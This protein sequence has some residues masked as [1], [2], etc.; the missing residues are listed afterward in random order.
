MSEQTTQAIAPIPVLPDEQTPSDR[1]L[2][3]FARNPQ[4]MNVAQGQLI[5][6]TID[7]MAEIRME[8]ADLQE[9][10]DIA[11]KGGWKHTTLKRQLTRAEGRIAFYEK[12]KAALAAGYCIVPNFPIDIFAIRTARGE[13]KANT[14]TRVDTP[15]LSAP[16]I[17]DQRS[18]SPP[19]GEG[20]YVSPAAKTEENWRPLQTEAGKPQRTEITAWADSFLGVDFP[21]A[22]AQPAVLNATQLAMAERVFDELGVSPT[23]AAAR[24]GDPMVIGRI[25]APGYPRWQRDTKALSFVVAWF[26]RPD[27]DLNF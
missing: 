22:F 1:R 15:P 8:M 16:S 2:T 7:K 17:D 12:V 23:R 18:E 25:Y 11:V 6:W 26:L 4:E 20:A 10:F 13:P 9:N 19:L 3:V 21:F 24:K 14:R 27:R 5:R